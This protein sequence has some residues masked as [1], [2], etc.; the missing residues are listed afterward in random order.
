MSASENSLSSSG[1][2]LRQN[3]PLLQTRTEDPELYEALSRGEYCLVLTPPEIGK[4]ARVRAAARLG[5]GGPAVV[6]LNLAAFGQYSTTEEWYEAL[7]LDLGQQLG[8]QPEM[9]QF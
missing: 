7:L 3:A 6:V 2:P 8:L 9:A 4:L 1:G 5:E